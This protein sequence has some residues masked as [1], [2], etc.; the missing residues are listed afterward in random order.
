MKKII[1]LI[2]LSFSLFA[3]SIQLKTGWNLIGILS[4]DAASSLANNPDVL[5]A[6]GGGVGGGGSFSYDKNYQQYAYGNFIVGQGYWVK[7]QKDTNLTYNELASIP[8]KITLKE[9]W[10]LIH[11][12]S[13]VAAS[14]LANYPQI[15]IATGGGVGGGGS[16]SYDKNYQQYAYG[17]S[18]DSQGYWVKAD[19]QFDM[20]FNV[21]N[22]RAWG[23]GGDDV[24]SRSQIR[25]N[26]VSYTIF[27]YSTLDIAQSGA[28]TSGTYTAFVGTFLNKSFPQVK[29]SEDYLDKQIVLKVFKSFTVFDSTTLLLSTQSITAS[30]GFKDVG[31]IALDNPDDYRPITAND[32]S[33]ELPPLAPSF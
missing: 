32:S 15:L 16:F 20:Q 10:N 18:L 25:I 4:N 33:I 8:S 30:G 17:T 31:N 2:L 12:L 28:S 27:A 11:F 21:F 5:I 6:T 3:S 24:S 29:I 19:S 1:L 26:G 9:G 14:D 23:V 13:P 7:V 22:Y